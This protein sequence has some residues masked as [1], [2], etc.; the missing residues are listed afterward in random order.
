[1][2]GVIELDETYPH[3]GNKGVKQR[4]P[5]KR[6]LRKRGRSTWKDDKPPVITM[7]K[8]GK[9]KTKCQGYE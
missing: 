2:E 7:V 3:A 8:R 6:G 4:K 5:K 9:T 1:M